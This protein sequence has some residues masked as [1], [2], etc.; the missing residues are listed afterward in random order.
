MISEDGGRA[1][2]TTTFRL[3]HRGAHLTAV[4][5][6]QTWRQMRWGWG[7][8]KELQVVEGGRDESPQSPGRWVDD[9]ASG[10]PVW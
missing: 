9:W 4:T 5:V 7:S 10:V 3:R 1:R 2:P 8:K 6:G